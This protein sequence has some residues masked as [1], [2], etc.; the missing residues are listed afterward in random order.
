MATHRMFPSQSS[1]LVPMGSFC[2]TVET[3]CSKTAEAVVPSNTRSVLKGD[4]YLMTIGLD[5][6]TQG[7]GVEAFLSS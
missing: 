5:A 1:T 2:L 3:K 4:I 7:E 6:Q